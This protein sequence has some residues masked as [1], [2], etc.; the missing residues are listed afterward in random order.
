M[1]IVFA[2]AATWAAPGPAA[3]TE[4]LGAERTAD[5][6]QQGG[7]S[8]SAH[9]AGAGSAP[10]SGSVWSGQRPAALGAEAGRAWREEWEEASGDCD[11][12]KASGVAA[13]LVGKWR[14]V[15]TV[16]QQSPDR[17]AG[18]SIKSKSS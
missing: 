10:H 9:A 8:V 2:R 6:H 12:A 13:S 16:A 3:R 15:R 11:G 1:R 17:A 7:G 5:A 18:G 14:S 4:K